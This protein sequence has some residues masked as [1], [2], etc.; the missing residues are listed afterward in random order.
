M[1]NIKSLVFEAASVFRKLM[2]C[3]FTKY[4]ILVKFNSSDWIVV[5][6]FSIYIALVS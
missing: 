2:N 5:L 3:M 6:E 4:M 1:Q